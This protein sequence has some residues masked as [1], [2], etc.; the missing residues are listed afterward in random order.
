MMIKLSN[1]KSQH[2]SSVFRKLILAFLFFALGST[3]MLF[4]QTLLTATGANTYNIPAGITR[5]RIECWGGGGGGGAPT[6]TSIPCGGG[7]GGAYAS[8]IVDVSGQTSISVFVGPGG[9]A[10]ANGGNSYYGTTVVA[11][12]GRGGTNKQITAG[13]GGSVANS[14]G[15]TVYAGGNGANGLNS[16]SK[17]S[18]GGGGGAGNTGAGFNATASTGGAG[19]IQYGGTGANGLTANGDGNSG[20]TYGGGGS[21]GFRSSSNYTGGTGANGLV[22][23]TPLPV[24]VDATQG[25]LSGYY[26]NLKSAFDA[27]NAGTHKGIITIQILAS[28]NETASA[29][30]NPSGSGSSSFT[31]LLIYPANP[32]LTVS[33]N[34]ND[35]LLKLN[36]ADGVTINGSLL[37]TNAFPTLTFVNT[38]TGS[39]ASTILFIQDACNNTVKYCTLQGNGAAAT[40]GVVVFSTSSAAGS[41][42]DDNII[43]YCKISGVGNTSATRP[44]NAVYSSGTLNRENSKITIRN[45]DVYNFFNHA[46]ESS[47]IRLD[48]NTTNCTIRD[49]NF[50]ETSSYVSTVA[51]AH[52]VIYLNN[53]A[54]YFTI[55][56]NYIGGSG[57]KASG[58]WTKSGSNNSF[59][60]ISLSVKSDSITNVQGN[61]IR[62]MNFTNAEDSTW[63][64]IHAIK[65]KV[66]IG[67]LMSDTIGAGVGTG[68]IALSYTTASGALYGIQISST[69]SVFVHNNVIG[70]ITTTNLATAAT[71][72][73]GIYKSNVG[74]AVSIQNNKVGGSTT[75]NS[76]YASSAATGTVQ[77][78]IG[79]YS[80]S[81]TS[82]LI[83]DNE[84]SNLTNATTSNLVSLTRGIRTM[85]GVNAITGNIVHD[86]SSLS[87]NG[88]NYLNTQLVGIDQLSEA[89]GTTQLVQG[90]TVYSLKNT[91][92]AKI[93]MYGIFYKGPTTGVSSLDRNF[94]H[95][96]N[97]VSTDQA[98]LHG[99]SV[100]SGACRVTNNVIFLGNNITTGCFIWGI[101]SGSASAMEFY[102]NTIYLSGQATTGA[103][104]TYAFRDISVG[105]TN[106]TLKN[107][108]FWNAR[109][110]TNAVVSHFALFL[111]NENGTV[112]IDYNDYQYTQGFAQVS[113]VT[114]ATFSPSWKIGYDANSLNKDPLLTNLGGTHAS[115]YQSGTSLPCIKILAVDA[116][117]GYK[118][119]PASATMGAW[120][121]TNN[122]VEIWKNG[123]KQNVFVNLKSAFDAINAGT[124]TGSLT[125]KITSNTLET[126]SAILYNSGNTDAGRNSNYTSIVIYPTRTE[127]QI[128]GNITGVLVDLNGADNVRFDGRV[129]L[130]GSSSDI[131]LINTSLDASS[132]TL[133][134][135]NSAENDT[136]QYCY[137]KG[138]S[139]SATSGIVCLSTSSTGNGNDNNIIRN[140]RFTN[141][142]VAESAKVYNALYSYGS[143]GRENSGVQLTDNYFYDFRSQNTN[144]NGILIDAY[145]TDFTISGN[146]FY[147][148]STMVTTADLR[149]RAIAIDNVTGN[150]FL[151]SGNY[152]GGQA[153]LCQGANLELGTQK[154]RVLDYQ[155][156]YL[157]VGSTTATSVQG[158]TIAN[159]QCYSTSS[160]PF[161]GIYLQAGAFNVGTVT[162]NIIG[163][164]VGSGNILLTDSLVGMAT[165]YGIYVNTT[166]ATQIYNNSIGGI[167][168]SN[169][170]TTSGHS[171]YGIYKPNQLGALNVSNNLVGSLTT[172]QSI[173]TSSQSTSDAQVVC[174]IKSLGSGSVAMNGNSIANLQNGS[175]GAAASNSAYGI[176]IQNNGVSQALVD[177]NFV[178][179]LS[180]SSTNTGN[181]VVGLYLDG[182]FV[183][184]SNNIVS[185]GYNK[186]YNYYVLG[187]YDVGLSGQISNIYHNTSYIS[188]TYS[189]SGTIATAYSASYFKANNAGTSVL[190]NNIFYN[191]SVNGSSRQ[192]ALFFANALGGTL[193]VDYND[194]YTSGSYLGYFN[195][196]RKSGSIIVNN[197][198]VNSISIDPVFANAYSTDPTG[199]KQTIDL[200]GVV[201][202]GV[203]S[204]FGLFTR[205]TTFPCLGAWERINKW[206]GNVSVDFNT[207]GNWTAGVVP[208]NWDNVV[209]DENP[210][211]PC[212]MDQQRNVTDIVNAQSAYRFVLNGYTLNIKGKMLFTNGAQVDATVSGSTLTYV[213]TSPQTLNAS[214]LYNY[215][216]YNL[217]INNASN[218][219]LSGSLKLLNSLS[220][221]TGK[222]N[223][224]DI[225][226]TLQFEGGVAQTLDGN[227]LLD[228]K[229]YDMVVN[230]ASNVSLSGT[231]VLLHTLSATSGRLNALTGSTVIYSG[232]DPQSID[233]NCYLNDKAYNLTASNPL[234][235]AL[236]TNFTIDNDLTISTGSSMTVPEN[237]GLT[238]TGL[239]SNIAGTGGLQLKSSALG[240]ASLIQMNNGVAA[241]VE[242]YIDGDTC[243]WHFLSSPVANQS[244]SGT[245]TPPGTFGDGT[246][247]DLYVWDE[248]ASCWVYNLNNDVA[249]TWSSIH[250]VNNFINGRGYLYAVQ[251]L[252]PTKQF[253]GN[254][255]AGDVPQPLTIN[256]AGIYKGFNLIGN[257]YPSSMDWNS[258]VGFD[259]SMLDANGGGYFIWTWS[260]TA[261][262]YGVY[263]SSDADGVGTNNVTRYI[264]PMQA[265]FVKAAT[266]GTFAF[267]NA[268]RVHDGA[269]VWLKSA[270]RSSTPGVRLMV[271]S[272]AGS[273]EI[274]F[275]FGYAVNQEGAV[276]LFSPVLTAPSLFM[277]CGGVEYSTRHLTDTKSNNYIPVNFKPGVSGQYTIKGMF[278]PS[279]VGSIILEDRQTGTMFNMDGGE[280]YIFQASVS[281]AP[282]RFVLHFG[283]ITPIIDDIRPS[284]WMNEGELNVYLENM[285]G[286]FTIRVSDVQGRQK[287]YKKMSG[288]ERCSV[289]LY[290]RG[291]YVVNVIGRVKSQS[292]KVVY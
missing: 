149:L 59:L 115:D 156:I 225:G 33:G 235:L 197:Q 206:K 73:Y 262:N 40:T 116:D 184:V 125:I 7:G 142:S 10:G 161:T 195:G 127:I 186:T 249:P 76:I 233:G 241:T 38:N 245:W 135:I 111:N 178:Y 56:G 84:I 141:P 148:T 287:F 238:V 248:P 99:L 290:S 264:A 27:I 26:T 109:S 273:D 203:V 22:V 188:G 251:A 145:S 1:S 160:T 34:I 43:E 198:D 169:F 117:Y 181:L 269:S 124:Y 193:T 94:V 179:E 282:E 19:K 52:R 113:G 276:K 162:G 77:N 121:F 101:W 177:H 47:G 140:C 110:N 89:A 85:N 15:T 280:S 88:S 228:N 151:I 155:P 164:P 163:A 226:T 237:K 191:N 35:A 69:D 2:V 128:K 74:G 119:R 244:I 260:T 17:Y 120:E 261:N 112:T 98:Y 133:R 194:Y 48:A 25:T 13:A 221:S 271:S 277:N 14:V 102:H 97:I 284:I 80:G 218:V 281:D 200:I 268:G 136:I 189:F 86:L 215:A 41:G 46:N 44:F 232:T 118:V 279:N 227:S 172:A 114:Y 70:S 147:A 65:G 168:T 199:Y 103:S 18:G 131:H 205:S 283:T 122:P 55:Q 4:A 30:L 242:R 196:S 192:Y 126:G 5:V 240:T 153:P 190:Q 50:Y 91:T 182:G 144:S 173:H 31:S 223:A 32:N 24:Q 180:S 93:E 57:P 208:S 286:D 174:G 256:S 231:L 132:A 239:I 210:I 137:L 62:N 209:F 265:F 104:N 20:G 236:N 272:T 9:A 292:F 87:S 243:A 183:Q 129:N 61:V 257:P 266:A 204:D 165:S 75:P 67:T 81:S 224:S 96:F 83:K 71:S 259:R 146:S 37:Q 139:P 150:N 143:A 229:L 185:L 253:V 63:I 250:T 222:L 289:P 213:G 252:T 274:K 267:H 255:N 28:T 107:N 288:S 158:N 11:E 108:I 138:A 152:I 51:S 217:N 263:N 159:F 175:T 170:G 207:P 23:I 123:S 58:V 270:Q 42:N 258:A 202:T 82:A 291:V 219:T 95:T 49:N 12:G 176:W 64:G 16:G 212:L 53:S 247:Y 39:S 72:I 171:F 78:L 220:A 275:D 130:T 60:G 79:I 166:D 254:L 29:V 187:I 134:F 68:S 105:S 167:T 234:G 246:G 278:D 3:G 36:G 157:N 6:N 106:R 92:T 8:G 66:R 216:V 285:V 45:N 54:G 21:G 214:S 154:A 90:N 211:R 230:N 201:G 100:Q